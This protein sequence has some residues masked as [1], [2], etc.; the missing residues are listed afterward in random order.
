MK[1]LQ[2]FKFEVQ[3]TARQRSLMQCF[4]GACRYVFNKALNHQQERRKNG[5]SKLSYEELCKLLTKWRASTEIPWLR[6]APAQPQ[7][8]ALK[9]LERA[10]DNFF[11][12]RAA[13][14]QFKRKGKHDSFRY[15]QPEQI[16]LEQS[17]GR[18]YLPKLGWLRYRVSRNVL[19]N[20]RNVT[21]SRQAGR[22]FISIQTVR[23][24][25]LPPLQGGRVGVDMGIIRFATLSDG[26]FL[27][28]LNSFRRHEVTLRR[29]MQSLSR[30]VQY[31]RNWKKARSQVQRIHARIANSRRDFLHKATTDICKK[32][33]VVFVENL[34]VRS[35][36]H[37]ARGKVASPGKQVRA[38]SGLNKAILDQ[39][40]YE[41]RR[42]LAYKLAWR[43]GLLVAVPPH[44]TSQTCPC[45]E[46]VSALNRHEQAVFAC[47]SCG[48]SNNADVVAA[49]NVLRRGEEV[50]SNEGR[51]YARFA[52]E[53][54]NAAR[55]P[56]AGTH[57]RVTNQVKADGNAAG[58]PFLPM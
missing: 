19:G 5:E 28:P 2:A 51:D 12:K 1:R 17:S 23:E 16:K 30:K 9:D 44:F 41:F 57:R 6:E 49:I 13:A 4:A 37:S 52:C 22:W 27:S 56:A 55:L 29:A 35:M 7:Q 21:V 50:L 24:V 20:L 34:R 15:P 33:A 58:F 40:W 39:G 45:C 38:K 31:G 36:S 48:Y 42:Q 25:A 53:V 26:A 10:Y 43:G 18:I 11:A 32:H 46:H 14:P 54:S 47:Q 8:Q 3:V